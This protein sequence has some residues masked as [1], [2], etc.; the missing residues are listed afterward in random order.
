MKKNNKNN[1][2]IF[3]TFFAIACVIIAVSVLALSFFFGALYFGGDEPDM[4]LLR[5]THYSLNVYDSKNQLML[6]TDSQE[7]VEYSQIPKLLSDAF[8]AVEDKRFYSH[9]GIDFIRVFGA[10]INNVKG[11]RTQGASTITQQLVKNTYLSSEQTF[12]RKFKEMQAAIKLEKNLSKEEILEYYLN[13]LYFGSGEYGVKNASMRFFSKELSQLNALE[14][15]MLAGIVKSPTKYNP[16]N[17]YDNSI[18]RAKVVLKLMYEQNIISEDIYG[19]YKNSDIIIQNTINE[20]TLANNYLNSA[21][22]EASSIL[23]ISEK[24]LLSGCYN[25]YT[26]YDSET[27][28]KLSSIVLNSNYYQD[29]T[30]G[31]LG[32]ICDNNSRGI[33]AFVANKNVNV[34]E[35]RRQ[36]GSTIKP[37]ACYAPA[38]DQGLI[39]PSTRILDEPTSFGD[40]SPS[41]F[42][43][44]Y[45]GWV[46][47]SDC[48]ANSLNVPSVKIIQQLG[49]E[50][51]VNYLKKMN[52]QAVD[53]DKNL[54][55]ALG[56]MTY[57]MNMIE[58]LGG[59]S[60]LANYGL[61]KTPSFI[62]KITDK[63][64][65]ILYDSESKIANRVFDEQSSYLMTDML[66][67]CSN[68][69]TAKKLKSL[70]FDIACK[71][72][73]VSMS[74]KAFNSDIFSVAYTSLDTML[75]W[76]GDNALDASQTGGG[77]TT[78][79]MKNFASTY[80]SDETP[81]N[82]YTPSGIEELNIDKY[83]YENLNEIV[84]ASQNAP[85][86]TVIKGLFSQ[87]CLPSAKDSTY[88]RIAID[89][90]SFSQSSG[91]VTIN[92]EYNPKLN[93][94]I[95]KRDFAKGELLID[96]IKCNS[97]EAS[98]KVDV[99]SFFGNKITVIPYYVDDN[100]LEIIGSPYKFYS[101][102]IISNIFSN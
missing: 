61:Y 77:T 2:K 72:G 69:G 76:Q 18:A 81:E 97:G 52:I 82:F 49:C 1:K 14:C 89:D 62:N 47:A 93:Y 10:L 24:D 11:N 41:N 48:I 65:N 75:F 7:Y 4:N 83:S 8:I 74:N 46:S 67:A 42:K 13:M 29:N 102:S 12:S 21:I 56:G 32:L 79:M 94:K 51:A 35:Y 70:N 63:D 92:F 28:N 57:G 96:D 36:V 66:L 101:N 78:L 39:S 26:Y 9:H 23:G 44:Q 34:F 73:T 95:Y 80:Y 98:I 53:E 50:T 58:L 55:L 19:S 91:Y 22:Y 60:T 30:T 71:T 17:N 16:I 99:D 6:N 45:Y 86:K 15:A 85:Q 33:K 25:L 38:L 68:N 3:K 90:I 27:Q 43:D 87:K 59:Y 100:N 37:L 20:N 84:L 88:D 5:Q 54:A 64:G 31:G 40:Y